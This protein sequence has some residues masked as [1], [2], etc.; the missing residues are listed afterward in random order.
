[1]KIIEQLRERKIPLVKIRIDLREFFSLQW[2]ELFEHNGSKSPLHANKNFNP[3][4]AALTVNFRSCSH[5]IYTQ[6]HHIKGKVNYE[7][8]WFLVTQ[9]LIDSFAATTGDCQWIHTDPVRAAVQSPYRSTIA[10]GFLVL[11]LI[12]QLT[13]FGANNNLYGDAKLVINR[14]L[15]QVRFLHPIKPNHHI[16]ALKSVIDVIP[17]KRGFEVVEEIRI[18]IQ[19]NN[20]TACVAELI[21]LV[22]L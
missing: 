4:S 14:G 6:L 10:H 22:I 21:T 5:P 7:G 9:D 3:S 11:A 8:R 2:R 17:I 20:R 12:P 18:E 15:N 13:E 16:R 1:M 19:D